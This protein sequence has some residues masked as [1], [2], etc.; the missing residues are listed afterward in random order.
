MGSLFILF[1]IS[2]DPKNYPAFFFCDTIRELIPYVH[3]Q[4]FDL[5]STAKF[6]LSS[7]YMHLDCDELLVLKFEDREAEY[8][9]DTLTSAINSPDFKADGISVFEFLEI[10]TNMTHPY[11]STE[12]KMSAIKHLSK[13]KEKPVKLS[14]FDQK[15]VEAAEELVH[16]SLS[17][18]HLNVIS[19]LESIFK[20]KKFQG[21][22]CKLLWNLLHQ[23]NVKK[24][25]LCNHPGIC[26]ALETMKISAAP[27]DQLSSHCCLWLLESSN[28][29]GK[30]CCHHY[31]L[32]AERFCR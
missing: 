11:Q 7:L 28:N 1:N 21:A 17:L 24:E 32:A 3:A 13:K 23:E 12:I 25:V 16:N 2:R 15:M 10:L 20:E 14:Y 6:T 8:C 30:I 4:E 26:E 9:I 29:Q 19:L 22:A 27:D 18:I 31:T 5:A